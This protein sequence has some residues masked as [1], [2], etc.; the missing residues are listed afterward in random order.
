VV[1]YT[2]DHGEMAGQKEMWGKNNSF[3]QSAGIPLIVRWPGHIDSNS[4][5]DK[6]C[7]LMDIGPTIVDTAG[8]APMKHVD[9]RSLLPLLAGHVVPEWKNETLVENTLAYDIIT[10][11][12]QK[13][14]GKTVVPWR[15]IVSDN[16][17][18]TIYWDNGNISGT[19]Y[20][21]DTDPDET[22]NV[23]CDST[24]EDIKNSLTKKIMRDWDPEFVVK[25][26][27]EL[28]DNWDAMV[29][30][31]KKRITFDASLVG[32]PPPYDVEKDVVNSNAAETLAK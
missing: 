19:L 29:K 31:G 24:Y 21:I 6:V 25:K 9:G 10:F 28:K 20:D 4:K 5:C 11:E 7:N 14:T 26:S 8:A 12:W 17:K 15:L 27:I 1:I 23:Y 2:S 32:T 30:A 16:W 13:P 3:E 18:L 22:N